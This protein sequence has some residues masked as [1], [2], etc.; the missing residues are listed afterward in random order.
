MAAIYLMCSMTFLPL[1][2]ALAARDT[3]GHQGFPIG[4]P[5]RDACFQWLVFPAANERQQHGLIA[6]GRDAEKIDDR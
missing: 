4:R 3:R 2:R 1:P 6:A 5:K